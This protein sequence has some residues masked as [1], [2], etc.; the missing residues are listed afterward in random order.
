MLYNLLLIFLFQFSIAAF[1]IENNNMPA[2]SRTLASMQHFYKFKFLPDG[3]PGRE[4]GWA[5]PI[6][7]VYVLR[8]Y[9]NQYIKKPTTEL[10]YA[11]RKVANATINRMEN[12]NGALVFWYEADPSKGARIYK[13]HYSGLTQGY[14][15]E[16]LY[17]SGKLLN[18]KKIIAAA[19]KAFKSLTIPVEEGGVLHKTPY[20]PVIAEVPQEP[21]S[22][23]LNGWQSALI[24]VNNYA[25]LSGSSAA[26]K[27]FLA[28][29]QAMLNTLPYYDIPDLKNSRYGLTGFA[30]L[31]ITAN[32]GRLKISE[33]K[34]IVPDEP[35][36]L[37]QTEKGTR[38][39]NY[40]YGDNFKVKDKQIHF[41]D[42]Q[43]K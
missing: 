2:F 10:N 8:D 11:I 18:D 4:D 35:S 17:T 31:R 28:S 34:L 3:Y 9:N 1:A 38:W 14:Y 22:W 39:Q 23:I 21:N 25:T 6:Y 32:T 42:N 12:F 40:F 5:H 16:T 24:S 20:G 19:E 29:S 43:M 27:L 7:G 15:S 13:K 30:Y 26:K 37:I 36:T 41:D 33:P